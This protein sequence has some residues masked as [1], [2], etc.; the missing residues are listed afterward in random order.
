MHCL[1]VLCFV[2]S[3]VDK[4]VIQIVCRYCENFNERARRGSG[5]GLKD[6]KDYQDQR[7]VEEVLTNFRTS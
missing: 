3:D 7:A 2:F 1:T 4:H 6:C 5:G